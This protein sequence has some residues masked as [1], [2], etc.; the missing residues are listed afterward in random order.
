[1]E[2]KQIID[3]NNANI[4]LHDIED[5]F[6]KHDLNMSERQLIISIIDGTLKMQVQKGRSTSMARQALNGLGLGGALDM[7]KDKKLEE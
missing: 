4:V 3:M 5:I 7:M 6:N 2:R 1:M